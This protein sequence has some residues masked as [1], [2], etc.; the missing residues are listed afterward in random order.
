MHELLRGTVVS[1]FVDARET[2]QRPRAAPGARRVSSLVTR[3]AVDGEARLALRRHFE[4]DS[5]V[6]VI[7]SFS[8]VIGTVRAVTEGSARPAISQEKSH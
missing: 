5:N 1:R 6:S 2:G 3:R 8:D 4:N 7:A